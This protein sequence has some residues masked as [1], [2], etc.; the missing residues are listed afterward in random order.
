MRLKVE[1]KN[2]IIKLNIESKVQGN[3]KVKQKYP[4]H[5]DRL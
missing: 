5:K 1:Y 2:A 3:K 4:A